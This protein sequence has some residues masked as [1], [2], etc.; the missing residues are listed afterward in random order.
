M[1]YQINAGDSWITITKKQYDNSKGI[2]DCRVIEDSDQC[3]SPQTNTL[4]SQ[5]DGS[6]DEDYPTYEQIGGGKVWEE[7]SELERAYYRLA[8]LYNANAVNK[9]TIKHLRAG[10]N[11]CQHSELNEKSEEPS[12]DRSQSEMADWIA[13]FNWRKNDR[14]Y[15]Y[16]KSFGGKID[17]I[18]LVGLFNDHQKSIK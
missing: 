5:I 6:L 9:N 8:K 16:N 12:L 17:T 11:N 18:S 10:S 4:S 2:F 7:M 1:K 15:W 13:K 14:G 3:T